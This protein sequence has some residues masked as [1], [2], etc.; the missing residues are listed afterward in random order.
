MVWMDRTVVVVAIRGVLKAAMGEWGGLYGSSD[1][2]GECVSSRSDE[3]SDCCC[4]CG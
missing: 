1:L 3:S 2:L 4:C